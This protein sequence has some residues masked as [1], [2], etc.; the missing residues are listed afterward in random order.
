MA[1]YIQGRVHAVSKDEARKELI[2]KQKVV[3]FLSLDPCR[4][5]ASKQTM[6]WEYLIEV[7]NE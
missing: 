4:I 5:Q 3:R 6:W 7:D 1:K 2:K